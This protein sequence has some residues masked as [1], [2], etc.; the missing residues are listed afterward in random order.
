LPARPV[1]HCLGN[2]VSFVKLVRLHG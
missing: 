1:P 2:Q